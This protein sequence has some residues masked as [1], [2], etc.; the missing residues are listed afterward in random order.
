MRH[1]AGELYRELRSPGDTSSGDCLVCS[2]TTCQ[3]A[4]FLGGLPI[5]S[6]VLG[7]N[8]VLSVNRFGPVCRWDTNKALA[9]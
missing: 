1:V 5:D 3:S 7:I 4:L 8:T 9:E 6:D 2:P